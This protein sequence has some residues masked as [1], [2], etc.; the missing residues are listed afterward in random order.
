MIDFIQSNQEPATL[1][2]S[3]VVVLSTVV[4]AVLTVLLVLE[5]RQMRRAQLNPNWLLLL[6]QGK[7][8]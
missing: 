2:F 8:L 5:T 3:A 1:I 6:S 4:Y 7:N